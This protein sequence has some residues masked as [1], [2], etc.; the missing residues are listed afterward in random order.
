[1]SIIDELLALPAAG[2]LMICLDVFE[3][4]KRMKNLEHRANALEMLFMT[5][6]MTVS[7]Y[8]G[9]APLGKMPTVERKAWPKKRKGPPPRQSLTHNPFAEALKKG[10][11]S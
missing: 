4:T 7:E 3:A 6:A 5:M 10:D 11:D 2:R 1:M 9:K 8:T